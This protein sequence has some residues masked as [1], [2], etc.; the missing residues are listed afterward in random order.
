MLAH[1]IYLYDSEHGSLRRPW[2]GT[3]N[4]LGKW[5][6]AWGTVGGNG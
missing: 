5:S 4:H 3:G 2:Y 6:T 1:E